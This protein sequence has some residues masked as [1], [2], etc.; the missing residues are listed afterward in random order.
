MNKLITWIA[1]ALALICLAVLNYVEFFMLHPINGGLM[2]PDFRFFGYS[3]DQFAQWQ[4]ALG[5]EGVEVYIKWFPNGIDKYYPALVGMAIALVLHQT[6]NR[7]P[8]YRARTVLLKNLILCIFSL[9][10]VF[11]DYFENLVVLDALGAGRNAGELMIEFASSMTALK[12]TFL[13]ISLLVI[14]A[15]WLASLRIEKEEK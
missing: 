6:L 12:A 3:Y 14:A 10:Y 13:S 8:R 1:V 7:F 2:S 5:D 15:L 9:P 11:F 4:S